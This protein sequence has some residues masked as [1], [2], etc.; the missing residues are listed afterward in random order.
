MCKHVLG[1]PLGPIAGAAR[2][3]L[4]RLAG[5]CSSELWR[6]AVFLR[7]RLA[8]QQGKEGYS[9]KGRPLWGQKVTHAP[10]Q[11]PGLPWFPADPSAVR[12][13]VPTAPLFSLQI[14]SFPPCHSLPFKKHP[15]T[16]SY[17]ADQSLTITFPFNSRLH[18]RQLRPFVLLSCPTIKYASLFLRL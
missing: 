7:A 8:F 9:T 17:L 13:F 11:L 14:F 15:P 6:A 1:W 16:L 18:G 10:A 12:P 4:D 2:D 5:G 3:R